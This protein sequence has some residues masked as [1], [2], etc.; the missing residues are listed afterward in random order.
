MNPDIE[1]PQDVQSVVN[2]VIAS[3]RM[4]DAQKLD[5]T[6]AAVISAEAD[7][8]FLSETLES[9]LTQSVLPGMI[10][11]ADCSGA[12]KD[13]VHARVPLASIDYARGMYGSSTR[14]LEIQVVQAS[15]AVS[16]VSSVRI[17]L[18]HVN[19]ASSVRSLWLL[20]DDSRPA[21]SQCLE[22]MLEAW[23][24]AP[25][26]SVLGAKQLGWRGDAMHDVG[27]YA[28]MHHGVNSLVVDGEPDQ[29]QYDARQDVFMVDL[30]GSLMS[31]RTWH[32]YSEGV[33]MGVYAESADLCRRV[34]LS[35]GRVL[36]VPQAAVAHRRARLE[37]MRTG[38]GA[39]AKH[40]ERPRS[41][42]GVVDA[43][44]RYRFTDIS[45][46]AWLP[47]W[48][49]RFVV[50]L[51]LFI[52]QLTRKRPYEAFCELSAPWRVLFWLPN[53]I[54][55]R[56]RVTRQSTVSL[57]RLS[58]LVARRDQ[59]SQWRERSSAFENQRDMPLLSPLQ[60]AHLASRRR[61]RWA[62]SSVMLLLAL[63]G[64]LAVNH[65][66]VSSLL[67]GG[68]AYSSTLVPTGASF[69]QLVH[70][71]TSTYSYADVMGG[72]TPPAP[73]LLVLM[74]ASVLTM[75]HVSVAV[76]SM[77]MLAAPCA[78]LSFWALAGVFTRSDAVRCVGALA[79]FAASSAM[80]LY[81]DADLPMLTVMVFLPAA[82][83]FSFRAV[84]MYRT[85][86]LVSP[87]ASVQAAATAALCFIPA[88]A[89]EPQ[90]LLPLMVTFLV[91]LMFV[92]S[93]RTTLLLIPLPAAFVCAPTLVNAV[94]F[95]DEG[96]WRQIF[97]SVM[98][99]SSTRD[100]SPAS[101]D[102]LGVAFRA[103]GISVSDRPWGLVG[104]SVLSMIAVLA[105]ASL[106]LPF[107]LRSS[108]M[109]WVASL[110]G[111]ALALLAA[112]VCVAVD[113]AGVVAASVL[114][115]VSFTMMGLLACVCMVAG[116]AV[117]RFSELRQSGDASS[118]RPR[119]T[120][121]SVVVRTARAILVCLLAAMV[122]SCMVFDYVAGDHGQVRSSDSGLPM[123]A[124]DYL[125]QD[126]ARR[127]LAVRADGAGSVSY[128]SMRTR[129]GDLIDSSPAQR[130]EAVSGRAG[131]T[132]KAISK[133]C[134]RLLANADSD[135]IANLSRL[136][137]G[138]IYVVR[139]QSSKGAFEQLSSNIGASEGTQE[140]V[141]TNGGNY[142][143]LTIQD[144]A[145]Q[146]VDQTGFHEAHASIWR[147]A[148]LWCMGLVVAAY[149]LVALPRFR[150]EGQEES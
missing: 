135:A 64:G 38:A 86:D 21:S 22:I 43:R 143:R 45:M 129:R 61:R 2:D 83:A 16:F 71:A 39:A 103:F 60:T 58:V 113:A 6:V 31:V 53:A 41:Y 54:A 146:H 119:A 23:R 14:Q 67:S 88:V 121:D 139:G 141:G 13:T 114:P 73:F 80:G 34:C 125:E 65:T 148:W 91:F 117:Q 68:G 123:V 124:S 7:V 75:G 79:W 134:A 99:P 87:R 18:S 29:E 74:L 101:M 94:R 116:G 81:D 93:H 4:S 133:D 120:G 27:C 9:V 77:L 10:I 96:T 118:E 90:L 106:F 44:E 50:S 95:A 122:V 11:I 128:A 144:I 35:G 84:G 112:H 145:K 132:D 109:M 140:V 82:F 100:G 20:H 26:A 17:A 98:L 24:N 3:H 105:L 55:G 33:N 127:I 108:R 150:R 30:A 15:G 142:Y 62:W 8:R 131:D 46:L 104:L 111:F 57:R 49:W 92:R 97:G 107:M 72:Y 42:V 25:T 89:A 5:E 85:E 137:F 126:S 69:S 66:A 37:G 56:R 32:D 70:A 102:V 78:A 52:G 28:T 59:L 36:V 136:G 12:T 40:D 19:L 130:V 138:G 76:A 110:S 51:A 149:C 47:V 1:E 115:G 48:L 63:V 147:Y